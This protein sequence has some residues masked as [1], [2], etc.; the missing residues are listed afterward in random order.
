MG[1]NE[2][3]VEKLKPES[4]KI[5]LGASVHPYA[6]NFEARVKY[7][8]DNRAVLLK[9]V[10]STQQINLADK[11]VGVAL[12]HL[13]EV[14]LPLLL[15]VGPEY[16]IPTTDKRTQSYDFLSWSWLEKTR[17]WFRFKNRWYTPDIEGIKK[18]L[19]RGLN[20]GG[21]IIF[22]HCGLP[23]FA[24][25]LLSFLEHSDFPEVQRYLKQNKDD[26]DSG[27]CYADVSALSTPFRLDYFD[28]I[29][30][31]PPK[32]LLFGSD[33][34]TPV[35]E[36]FANTEEKKKDLKAMLEG[37]LERAIVPQDNL[38]DVNYHQLRQAFPGHPLFTNF[39]KLI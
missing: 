28:K 27:K 14:K 38:L 30:D 17:N 4:E 25:R 19:E 32:Y 33:Y 18:N 6:Q 37:H 21:K 36:I 15:H 9:W 20:A 34:P 13:A 29:A 22:A 35:F 10:P 2:Y 16:A 5:L 39:S 12:E 7:C 31:L 1:Q 26:E 24:N 11:K 8:L 3:I 23:Y